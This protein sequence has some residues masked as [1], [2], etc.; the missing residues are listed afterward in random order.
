MNASGII[1]KDKC[2]PLAGQKEGQEKGEKK[3][4]KSER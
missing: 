1:V 2:S 4:G 3:R